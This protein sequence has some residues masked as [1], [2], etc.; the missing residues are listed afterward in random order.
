MTEKTVILLRTFEYWDVE[1]KSSGEDAIEFV[2]E[3][4]FPTQIAKDSQYVFLAK[5]VKDKYVV[6][7]L[8]PYAMD[9]VMADDN[10]E[11]FN[12]CNVH[13]YIAKREPYAV[14]V[15]GETIIRKL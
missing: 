3:T 4:D 6:Y 13:E 1:N 8:T 14:M 12:K 5:K 9:V 15:N 10:T 2:K 11:A 7:L